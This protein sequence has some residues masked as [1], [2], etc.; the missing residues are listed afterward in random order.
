MIIAL[1]FVILLVTTFAILILRLIRPT[2]AYHWLVALLGALFIWP[3]L[4][5]SSGLQ[6]TVIQLALWV[7]QSIFPASPVFLWTRLSW[8][9]SLALATLLLSS[10]LI[11]VARSADPAYPR[12]AWLDLATSL[13]LTSA[14]LMA[15]CAGNLLTLLLVWASLDLIELIAWLSKVNTEES[16]QRVVLTF[17]SRIVSQVVLLWAVITARPNLLEL[18]II[19]LDPGITPFL[20]LSGWYSPGYPSTQPLL[21]HAAPPA[22]RASFNT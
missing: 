3:M 1:I 19:K 4:L 12:P 16:T 21:Q 13:A 18:S 11:D 6:R 8:S 22:T 20:L 17:S 7:P 15:V 10:I 9:F 14:S 5:F 2:F